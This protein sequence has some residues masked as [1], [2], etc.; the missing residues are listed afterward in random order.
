MGYSWSS[1]PHYSCTKKG[2]ILV[3]YCI[4]DCGD[5]VYV[6]PRSLNVNVKDG[7]EIFVAIAT[8]DGMKKAGILDKDVLFFSEVSADEIENGCIYCLDVNGE[9]ILRRVFKTRKGLKLK[10][11]SGHKEEVIVTDF[12]LLG[13]LVGLQRKV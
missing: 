12:T 10:R 13:K 7:K 1:R 4:L 6:N 8:G 9:R 11:E 3:E 2:G 5:N